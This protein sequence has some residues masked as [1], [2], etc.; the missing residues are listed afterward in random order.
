MTTQRISY[1]DCNATH[2]KWLEE[3]YPLLVKDSGA[4]DTV[5][6]ELI[7]AVSRL[8]YDWGNNG[9][10]N[11]TS[12]ACNFIKEVMDFTD[13][14][15]NAFNEVSSQCN[16]GGYTYYNLIEHITVVS[17]AVIKYVISRNGNYEPLIEGDMFTYADPDYADPDYA[18]D[19]Y[20][21]EE[22]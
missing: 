20:D 16:A 7:R 5:E 14:E 21:Y 3:N 2:S 12:G 8:N 10:C 13:E 4:S 15:Q 9:M 1:W 6:G 18:D 22:D 11:N 19:D 17:D